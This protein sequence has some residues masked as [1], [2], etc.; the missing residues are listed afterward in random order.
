MT[1]SALH[2]AA[3]DL[4]LARVLMRMVTTTGSYIKDDGIGMGSTRRGGAYTTYGNV[5]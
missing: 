5:C 2:S 1:C 3:L 4:L